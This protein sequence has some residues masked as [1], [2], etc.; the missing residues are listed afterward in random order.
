MIGARPLARGRLHERARPARARAAAYRVP[1]AARRGAPRASVMRTGAGRRRAREAA[2]V[3]SRQAR[4]RGGRA[5]LLRRPRPCARAREP[6]WSPTSSA[7]RTARSPCRRRRGRGRCAGAGRDTDTP[8]PAPL[9]RA[10]RARPAKRRELAATTARSPST[11]SP[12]GSRIRGCGP[13]VRR[14]ASRGRHAFARAVSASRPWRAG[15]RRIVLS[16]GRPRPC[17]LDGIAVGRGDEGL[18]WPY[19]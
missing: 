10:D 13:P 9:G 6:W 3:A 17:P 16:D 18:T 15:L 4:P 7:A 11:W 5:G 14:P 8:G 19:P 2:L 12:P 1:F